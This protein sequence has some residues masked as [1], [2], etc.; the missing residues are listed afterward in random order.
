M[1]DILTHIFQTRF[2]SGAPHYR[3]GNPLIGMSI[4][5]ILYYYDEKDQLGLFNKSPRD[6]IN[7]IKEMYKLYFSLSDKIKEDVEIKKDM[8]MRLNTY[9]ERIKDVMDVIT[10]SHFAKI[11]DSKKIRDLI[12]SL[13]S[14]ALT[15]EHIRKKNWFL[16]AKEI[17]NKNGFFHLE[18]NFP[19]LLHNAFDY[20]FV[21]PTLSY[22]WEDEIPAVEATTAYIKRGMTYLKQEGKMIICFERIWDALIE[23]LNK[24]KK[25]IYEIKENYIV[26]SRK[27]DKLFT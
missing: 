16:E 6:L 2:D 12:F 13:D 20:I 15:W 14:D 10:A 26:V 7:E 17:A 18:I 3:L 19:F 21:Q 9:K 23:E 25:Y 27:L 4:K 22:I 8:D 1:F 24:S 5:D 11:I